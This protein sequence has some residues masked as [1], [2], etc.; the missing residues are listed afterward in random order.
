MNQTEMAKVLKDADLENQVFK[1]FPALCKGLGIDTIKSGA[2]KQKF[3]ELFGENF[4]YRKT[5]HAFTIIKRKKVMKKE[6]GFD[7][8]AEP[9]KAMGRLFYNY[10]DS[11]GKNKVHYITNSEFAMCFNLINETHKAFMSA[12]PREC[13][14]IKEAMNK[15]IDIDYCV[16][17]NELIRDK[18]KSFGK[19]DIYNSIE[20][21][22]MLSGKE[23]TNQELLDL[24]NDK[25]NYILDKYGV[26]ID[27]E[28]RTTAKP[29]PP[30]AWGEQVSKVIYSY[31]PKDAD[32]RA[33]IAINEKRE[34]EGKP[35]YYKAWKIAYVMNPYKIELNG[36]KDII[37]EKREEL[38]NSR[39]KWGS[40][41]ELWNEI[42][43]FVREVW[44]G[45]MREEINV[46]AD[47]DGH[48]RIE[49]VDNKRYCE[50]VEMI[51]ERVK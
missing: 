6:F 27:K 32:K 11:L 4:E 51:K 18:I 15:L 28:T 43:Q 50:L 42:Y 5:G 48:L 34:E 40:Y 49:G 31:K 21:V 7:R 24:L 26:I 30:V 39:M 41:N 1:N 13:Y 29:A 36:E 47:D 17:I 33:I 20:E 3:L 37:N 46:V 23:V 2:S 44:Q 19:R 8:D 45:W 16:I 12:V 22:W 14:Q 38:V 10:M 25:K 35:R 9:Y